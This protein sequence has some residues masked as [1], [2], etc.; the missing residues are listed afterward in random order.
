MTTSITN[1]RRFWTNFRAQQ[2]V[3]L[4]LFSTF[5]FFEN[6]LIGK[7]TAL[8]I[9]ATAAR[10]YQPLL[11]LENILHKNETCFNKKICLHAHE[12]TGMND[13][14]TIKHL[15]TM[16]ID[17]QTRQYVLDRALSIQILH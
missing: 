14:E 15:K 2:N 1:I 4:P 12:E 6:L 10:L 11:L 16:T 17:N 8:S 7:P 5:F 3:E 9:S 13:H